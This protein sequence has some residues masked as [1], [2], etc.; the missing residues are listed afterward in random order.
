MLGL[1][2]QNTFWMMG[3]VS[4]RLTLYCFQMLNKRQTDWRNISNCKE[5]VC[6]IYNT[7][8]TE[9]LVRIRELVSLRGT[10]TV[11]VRTSATIHA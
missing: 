11:S 1:K 3:N 4:A 6:C 9:K 10:S 5:L 7:R 8:I 2:H